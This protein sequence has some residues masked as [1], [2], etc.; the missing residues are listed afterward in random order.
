[1]KDYNVY[2]NEFSHTVVKCPYCKR[3][4]TLSS[5]IRVRV[6]GI[7]VS[8]SHQLRENPVLVKG[9]VGKMQRVLFNKKQLEKLRKTVRC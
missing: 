8:L 7:M 6:E 2:E 5:W 1:M 4:F 9:R 3:Q